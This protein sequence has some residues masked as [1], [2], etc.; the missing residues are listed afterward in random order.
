MLNLT[1]FASR[2]LLTGLILLSLAF[3]SGCTETE[4]TD[5]SEQTESPANNE[6]K[7]IDSLVIELTGR[8]SVTVLDLLKEN[9]EV[10]IVATALGVFVKRIDSLEN[11][12]TIFWIYSVNDSMPE[13]AADRYQTKDGD[14]IR[15]HY[16]KL[17][18]K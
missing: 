13:I 4:K 12:S 14:Q 17:A 5:R 11:G 15:W 6:I 8:D 18:G 3:F 16:R 9:H 1:F 7:Y 10:G 2:R